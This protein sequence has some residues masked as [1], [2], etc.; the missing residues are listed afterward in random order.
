MKLKVYKTIIFI[1]ALLFN[2]HLLAQ[3]LRPPLQEQSNKIK[4]E[5]RLNVLPEFNNELKGIYIKLPNI[6]LLLKNL[7]FNIEPVIAGLE[8]NL[9]NVLSQIDFDIVVTDDQNLPDLNTDGKNY[10]QA[11]EKVKNLSKSYSVDSKDKLAIN[12]QYGKVVINTWKKNEIKVEV[13]IKAYESSDSKAQDLLNAVSIAESRQGDV[14]SYKTNIN[15]SSMNWWS[16]TKNGNE[17]K[18]GV[19][20]N[21]TVYMPSV[22]PLDLTNKYG[23]TTLS[24]FEGPVNINSSYGSL[25]AQNLSNP[26]NRIKISYGSAA[27]KSFSS[28]VLDVS[29][30]SLK[31]DNADKMSADI[32][33]S[34]AK[35]GRLT[36]SG[37]IDVA[38]GSCRI[39]EM[40]KNV[41]NLVINSSYSGLT[42]GIDESANFNFDV[43]VS[44]AGFNFNDDKVN[45]TNQTPDE[46]VKGFN[47]T[48]NYVGTYGKGS[49][50]RIII[51]SNY[52]GVKFL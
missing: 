47:P 39:E 6:D 9:E 2:Q 49:D 38:Y 23:S 18:R 4:S 36:S 13:E 45:I 21:Y 31:L 41:K 40:D 35:I 29:Y 15:K 52:G 14:I 48:K 10:V 25:A 50:A 34:S 16:R 17:E 43:T 32:R 12:N 5:K 30:G 20:V 37:K 1:A 26:A 22:N 8:Q 44:Y 3:D 11:S 28:G 51:K 33:Y 7:E 42:I 46:N 27:L 24:D 19:Q